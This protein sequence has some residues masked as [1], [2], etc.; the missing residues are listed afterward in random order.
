MELVEIN[1][2]GWYLRALRDDDRISDVAALAD[3]GVDDPSGYVAETE[4]GL[5]AGDRCVWAVCVPTTGELIALI[6]AR[7]VADS[8]ALRG[9]AR[10]GYDDA[11]AASIGPVSRYLTGA[12]DWTPGELESRFP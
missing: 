7:H 11:L 1:A 5:A 10:T 9:L 4:A 8:T 6:G 3:L 2:G 12:L